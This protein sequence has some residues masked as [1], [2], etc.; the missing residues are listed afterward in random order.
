MFPEQPLWGASDAASAPLP[1]P[2]RTCLCVHHG[3]QGQSFCLDMS[4]SLRVVSSAA[5]TTPHCHAPGRAEDLAG[6]ADTGPSAL[7]AATSFVVL[8]F[9]RESTQLVAGE[10]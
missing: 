4:P 7:L 1:R 8:I 5:R 3:A 2:A 9:S 10:A 6:K